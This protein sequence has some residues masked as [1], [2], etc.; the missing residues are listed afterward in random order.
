MIAIG[1]QN[2]PDLYDLASRKAPCL[3]PESLRFGVAGR[4]SAEGR[5]LEDLTPEAARELART[6]AA[7]GA[8][9]VAVCL[10]FSF[11]SPEHE[12]RLGQALAEEGLSVSLSSEIL[13]EFREYERAATTVA[14]AYVAPV[15]DAYLGE[16]DAGLPDGATLS[17]MQSSGGLITAQ[18]ARREPVRTILSG[19]AGGVVAALAL[20]KAAGFDRLITF[21]MGGTSTDVSLLDGGLSMSLETVVSGIPVKTPM[22]DIHTVGAG[23]GSLAWLDAGGALRVGPQSAGAD[24]GPAC[25]GQ[26]R[27]RSP[28]PTPICFWAD[29]P[30]DHFL[31]GAMPLFPDRLAPLFDDP[32]PGRLRA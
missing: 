31:G 25:Y 32:V 23:G 2:R 26:G 11:L 12:K 22:L 28:S 27:R 5:V 30:P 7:S 16:L 18:T 13:A 21:D 19:P 14:N 15:M 17:V 4:I 10:L 6:V 24:P 3:V 1:R 8:R 29:W 9:S 20:G